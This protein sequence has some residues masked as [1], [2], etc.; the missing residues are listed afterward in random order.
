MIRLFVVTTRGLES[1]SAAEIV[2]VPQV[3]IEATGYRRVMVGCRGALAPLLALR[4]VDDVFLNEGT[5][6][7]MVAE[8][9]ALT[10]IREMA[11]R[12]DLRRAAGI[13]EELRP[14]RRPP[15]FS[16]TVNFVGQ[17]NY[18][19]DEIKLVCAAGVE[20]GHHGWTYA[21]DDRDAD[22]NVRLF[23]EHETAHVGVRLSQ[24]PLQNR[25]Y[26][27]DH[28]PGSLR[29][30]V[31][32]AMARLAG[33]TG[34]HRL[35]LDPCCG[36]GTVLIE[37]AAV[38]ATVIGGDIDRQATTATVSN[39]ARAGVGVRCNLWDARALPL[40]NA[41]V[42]CVTTNPPWGRKVEIGQD[43]KIFYSRIGDEIRRVLGSEGRAVVL[44][45]A[46]DWVKAWGMTCRREIEISLYGRKPT[47][48]VLSAT[49]A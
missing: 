18:T 16:V 44:T 2:T 21:A 28:V 45:W 31:A 3:H 29:P 27:L 46:P 8:R 26:K 49:S 42:D 43:P 30:P 25:P 9:S 36:A 23:I 40:P 13:C 39:A 48:L 14:I 35:L 34:E 32:A 12:L 19:T 15:T 11:T 5:W 10:S 6:P 20:Q 41:S 38:G 24:A 4:T 22:L 17:R 33:A 7:G 37:A 1:V 47:L